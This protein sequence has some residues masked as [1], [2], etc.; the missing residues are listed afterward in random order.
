MDPD[1]SSL[2]GLDLLDLASGIPSIC[3]PSSDFKDCLPSLLSFSLGAEDS[4][5]G[6]YAWP[7][8]AS[9]PSPWPTFKSSLCLLFKSLVSHR[10]FS[11]LVAAGVHR[12]S[13]QGCKGRL[14]A[15][16]LVSEK[17]AG[18]FLQKEERGSS[19]PLFDLLLLE[20]LSV[21]TF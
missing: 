13:G 8:S 6:G 11:L 14:W 17:R 10:S 9:E 19:N 2:I 18:E 7:A 20:I 3:L 16:H 15:G 21:F 12:G 1:Q 4:H 5:L